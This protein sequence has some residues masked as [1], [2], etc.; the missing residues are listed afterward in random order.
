MNPVQESV[1]FV[2]LDRHRM[3]GSGVATRIDI[4]LVFGKGRD[5]L[6]YS[7][8]KKT[9]CTF[10]NRHIRT[11]LCCEPKDQGEENPPMMMT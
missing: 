9:L 11:R 1:E 5:L 2:I 3:C 10:D 4:R 7:P 6:R 8:L